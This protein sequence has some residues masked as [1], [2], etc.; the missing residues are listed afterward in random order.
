MPMFIVSIIEG[1]AYSNPLDELIAY[2]DGKTP[3]C[4]LLRRKIQAEATTAIEAARDGSVGNAGPARE[5]D[6]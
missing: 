1:R 3:A 4:D 2:S 6:E 5:Q